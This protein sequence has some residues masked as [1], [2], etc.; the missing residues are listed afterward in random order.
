MTDPPHPKSLVLFAQSQRVIDQ[1]FHGLD[2]RVA[3]EQERG[4]YLP[5]Y[6]LS[7][8]GSRVMSADTT[9]YTQHREMPEAEYDCIMRAWRIG[10]EHGYRVR[11][12]D[13]TQESEFRSWLQRHMHDLKEFPVLLLPDGRRLS[14]PSEFTEER[15]R[16]ALAP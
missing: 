9:E 7:P 5:A 11:L 15:L 6:A 2:P 12:I 1:V 16:A 10:E 13:V 3:S 8:L 14:G 4:G